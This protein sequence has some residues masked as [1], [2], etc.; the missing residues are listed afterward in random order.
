MSLSAGRG[1]AGD[2]AEHAHV[3]DAVPVGDGLDLPL[4]AYELC[5]PN[6]SPGC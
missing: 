3:K 1:V 4:G 5:E 6:S 2:R